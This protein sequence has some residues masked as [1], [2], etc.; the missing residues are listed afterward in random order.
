MNEK[1]L[2]LGSGGREHAL[3]TYISRSQRVSDVFCVPGN[4]EVLT[5][6]VLQVLILMTQ[7][8]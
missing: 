1:V 3:A 4:G 5:K 7:K 8:L 6:L 2:V